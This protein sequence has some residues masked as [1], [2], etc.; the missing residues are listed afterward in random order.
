MCKA[1][2]HA[3]NLARDIPAFAGMTVGGYIASLWLAYFQPQVR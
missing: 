1:R 3:G 2:L